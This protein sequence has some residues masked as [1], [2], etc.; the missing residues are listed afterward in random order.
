M[1]RKNTSGLENLSVHEKFKSEYFS[2]NTRKFFPHKGAF[3]QRE[4]NRAEG[5]ER[6]IYLFSLLLFHAKMLFPLFL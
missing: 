3:P 5:E 4:T 2:M 6:E 1:D